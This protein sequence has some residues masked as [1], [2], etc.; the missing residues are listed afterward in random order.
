MDDLLAAAKKATVES[1]GKVTQ[2]GM[3]PGTD[4]LSLNNFVGAYGAEFYSLDGS[5]LMMETAEMKKGL[6]FVRDLFVTHKVAPTPA[7]EAPASPLSS[8]RPGCS[9]LSS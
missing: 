3:A 2:F 4:Y 7:P 8:W 5:K 6:N 9:P 1:G